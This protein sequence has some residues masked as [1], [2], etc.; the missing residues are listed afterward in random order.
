MLLLLIF[1]FFQFLKTVSVVLAV[2]PRWPCCHAVNAAMPTLLPCQPQC[3]A[4]HVLRRLCCHTGP[5]ATQSVLPCRP[6]CQIGVKCQKTLDAAKSLDLRSSP[7]IKVFL[8]L[9]RHF[10]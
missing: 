5:A 3:L 10:F 9:Q 2:L 1:N 7:N 6:L 8:Y 4:G